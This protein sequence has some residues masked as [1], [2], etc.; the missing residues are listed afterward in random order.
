MLGP[1]LARRHEEP[2]EPLVRGDELAR[3]LGVRGQQI[4]R[5]VA[6]LEEAQYAGEIRTREDAISLARSLLA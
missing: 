3:E 1:A 4:G 6:E 2:P 5:L